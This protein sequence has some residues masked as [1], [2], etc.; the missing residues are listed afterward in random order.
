MKGR[1]VALTATL[2]CACSELKPPATEPVT[3]HVLNVRP[4][5]VAEQRRDIAIEVAMPRAWPG[6]DSMDMVYQADPYI[7]QRYA[8]NR[9]VDTPPRMLAPLLL[10]ALEDS[11]AFR[12]VVQPPLTAP[13]DFR[14]DTEVVRLVQ[15]FGTRPSTMRIA[16]RVQ[17][18]DL[19]A[20]RVV[21]ARVFEDAEPASTETAV[22]GATAA[23]VALARMLSEVVRFCV[24]ET[25]PG[26]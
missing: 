16:L 13:A 21:A 15:D 11:G 20:R 9:W 24:A 19:R 8:V 4:P 18:T 3:T 7:L 1:L 26:Q 5:V 6:F 22:G 23:N 2:L 25:A 14:L 17:V 12:A 10:R